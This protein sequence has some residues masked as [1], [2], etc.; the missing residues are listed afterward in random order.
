MT[1]EYGVQ[2]KNFF[3]IF[4]HFLPFYPTLP[5]LKPRESKLLKNEKNAWQ[6]HHFTQVFH[7]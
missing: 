3:L 6:Y 2:Q 5:L 1:P 7:K 4:D